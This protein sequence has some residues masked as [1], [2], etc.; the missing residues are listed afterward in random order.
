MRWSFA[1]S[2]VLVFVLMSVAA[3]G[4]WPQFRGPRSAAAAEHLNLPDT[5]DRDRNVL[6][7]VDVP[8][9]GWSSPVVSGDRVFLTAVLNDK[10]PP[11]RKGLYIQDLVGKIPPGEHRWVVY[12]LDL[13]SGKMLWSRE[14]RRGAPG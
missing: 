12:G 7:R 14:A 10:T 5:W 13:A 9:R 11:P 3:A 2:A 6:W 8:G 1:V 4:D